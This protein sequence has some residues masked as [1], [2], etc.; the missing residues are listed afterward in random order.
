MRW[1]FEAWGADAVFSG[2]DHIYERTLKD[3]NSDGVDLPYFVSGLGGRSLYTCGTPNAGSEV[4]FDDEYGSMVVTAS[5]SRIT[6]EFWSVAGGGTLVDS[7]TVDAP[8]AAGDVI[9]SGFQ[10]WNE[11]PQGSGAGPSEFVEL[12][13]TTDRT[14]SLAGLE[15]TAWVDT[16][17]D[18]A[19]EADWRLLDEGPDLSGLSIAPHSF[20]LIAEDGVSAVGGV[21]DL[22]VNMDLATGEG[23]SA[24][25]AIG[26][27]I[28]IDGVHMD[29]VLYGRHDGSDVGFPLGDLPFDGSTYPRDEVIRNTLGTDNFVEGLVWRVSPEDLY[30]GFAVEGFYTTDPTPGVWT[31][32][33]SNTFAAYE[34]RN[35]TA[36]AVPQPV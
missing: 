19:V 10:A 36:P 30:A 14:I 5:S 24:E 6:Y 2:H 1:P 8:L 31:S 32:P 17:G 22:E 21:H 4:C 9:V 33:H 28:V 11:I 12:F 27:E 25:R 7:Y 18:S 13:N 20:F 29:H 3:D 34:A 16:A 15:L 26:L 35:S 23:G